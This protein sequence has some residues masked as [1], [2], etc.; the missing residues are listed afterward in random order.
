MDGLDVLR[1]L[2]ELEA[3]APPMI[4]R[5]ARGSID[6]AVAAMKAGAYDLIRKPFDLSEVLA[7]G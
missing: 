6:S 1:K 4:L 2:R 3:S 7:T 5:T